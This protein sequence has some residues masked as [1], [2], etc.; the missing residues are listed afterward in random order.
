MTNK[1]LDKLAATIVDL[2]PNERAILIEK[3][4]LLRWERH[5]KRLIRYTQEFPE[6]MYA[7]ME[8]IRKLIK[9]E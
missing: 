7:A 2:T 4:K 9:E 5:T 8:K 1:E 6:A 3:V